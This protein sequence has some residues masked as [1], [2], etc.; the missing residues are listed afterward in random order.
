MR[1]L[2]C[3]G[4]EFNDYNLVKKTI[5]QIVYS[6][7][8]KDLVIIHG[9]A[10][11]ADYLG[12]RYCQEHNVKEEE[13]LAQW[14]IFNKNGQ[15]VTDKA[16]GYKRNKKMLDQGKPDLVVAFEGGNGTAHMV[17]IAENAGVGVLKIRNG[18]TK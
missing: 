13:Y 8:V 18:V 9:G 16:A 1:L 3:G 11:G 7:E 6:Y 10:R 12:K 5:K 17:D 4:R 2:I 15:K 14:N